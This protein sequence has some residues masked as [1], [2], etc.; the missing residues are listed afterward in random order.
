MR[1][2]YIRFTLKWIPFIALLAT[3]LLAIAQGQTELEGDVEASSLQAKTVDLDQVV[4]VALANNSQLK[5]AFFSLLSAEEDVDVAW[6]SVM[7]SVNSSINYTRNVEIPVTFIPETFF[8]PQNGDP[9]VLVPAEFGTDNDWRG[10]IS[11]SQNIFRGEAFVGISSAEMFRLLQREQLRATAEEVITQARQAYYG[12]LMAKERYRVQKATI[13]RIE[14]NLEENRARQKAGLLDD[15]D[16]LRLEV[17]L[18]NQRPQLKQDEFAINQAFRNLKMVMGLPATFNF[19]ISGQLRSFDIRANSAGMGANEGIKEVD[20]MT[21][22]VL[23]QEKELLEKNFENRGDL[24]VLQARTGLKDREIMAIKSRYLPTVTA[25]Y[26]LSWTA[27]EAGTPNFFEDNVRFQTIGVN[28]NLPLFEGFER[29]ANLQ[30]AQIQKKELRE[31]KEQ[32]ERQAL[33]E[34]DA[35]LESIRLA[36]ETEQARLKALEQAERGYNIARARLEKGVGSQLDVTNA[37]VQLRQA[38]LNY[39]QMVHDYLNAKASY[40]QAIGKVPFISNYQ[41]FLTN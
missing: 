30:K 37:E 39:A 21:P 38:E 24:R 27:S 16:V 36:Y 2:K 25:S 7:P 14:A 3:P 5:A 32:L 10:G 1:S 23:E 20:T 9:N 34:I 28:V 40:D 31:Q 18:S 13:E 4:Q 6:S 12:V 41:N 29:N 26:N 33:N 8:D 17:Q 22:L 35:A 15:Y 19:E 11:V